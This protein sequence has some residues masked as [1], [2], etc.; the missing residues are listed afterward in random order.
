VFRIFS[1]TKAVTCVAAMQLVEAGRLAL[2][3]PVPDI[4]EPALAAPQVL[5]GF[6]AAGKPVLRPAKRP[7]TLRQLMTHTAGFTYE[8]WNPDTRRYVEAGGA[9]PIISGHLAALRRPLAFDPGERW[10]YG[11]NID[12]IGRIVEALSGR[13]LDTYL[14][15]RIF[16]PL[17][18]A[19]TSFAASAE[20]RARQALLHL[21][22]ADGRL[23]P[24]PL[25]PPAVPEFFAG[26]GGL[27][28]T[29]P[30]YLRFLRMLLHGGTLDGVRI[31]M[32]ES[33][34]LMNQNQIGGLPAGVLRT[35]MPEFS[36]D[37]DFFPGARVS[38]GLGYMLNLEA[39][40][41]GRSAGTVSWA[42]LGNS[43]YWLDPVRR[44]TG[45]ILTQILPFADPAAVRLYGEFERGVC[46][47]A[48]AGR[49]I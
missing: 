9:P 39:G 26:G 42:G 16:A 7:I 43:Y 40:P 5:K 8:F 3:A 12:W 49:P 36:N 6:D 27:V 13:S 29:G 41:N 33:V 22:Q 15:E 30:D 10:E 14:R 17:G 2:D 25:P 35:V 38:W 11:I 34:T 45:V 37:V 23:V 19:D 32:P 18:M 47:L 44:V 46:A 20:Q 1:M 24:Q 21:R 28:S 48:D 31:L 4:G